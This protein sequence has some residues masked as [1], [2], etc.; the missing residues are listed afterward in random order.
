MLIRQREDTFLG[1]EG[2][3]TPKKQRRGDRKVK[4]EEGQAKVRQS[5]VM[6]W[7]DGGYGPM[8][9]ALEA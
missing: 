5:K 1:E 7:M 6:A 8:V 9:H 2:L 4:E 3:E